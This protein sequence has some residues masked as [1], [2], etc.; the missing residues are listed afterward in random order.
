MRM[1]FFLAVGLLSVGLVPASAIE[2][3]PRAILPAQPDLISI[4]YRSIINVHGRVSIELNIHGFK[5]V[6]IR[7]LRRLKFEDSVGQISAGPKGGIGTPY[8]LVLELSS[9]TDLTQPV[10]L[11]IQDLSDPS[12][13]FFLSFSPKGNSGSGLITISRQKGNSQIPSVA[14]VDTD[15]PC[16]PGCWRASASNGSCSTSKCCG[17][18]GVTFDMDACIITCQN[19]C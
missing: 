17:D 3:V 1:A 10:P 2:P 15:D 16:G 7:H 14:P 6:E 19:N 9:S 13:F 12:M 5:G 8:S 4:S 18:G 11:R